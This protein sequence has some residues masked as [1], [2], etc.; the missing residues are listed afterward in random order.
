MLGLSHSVLCAHPPTFYYVDSDE[1]DF[2]LSG[3]D[4]EISGLNTDELKVEVLEFLLEVPSGWVPGIFWH[5]GQVA[6]T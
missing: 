5:A 6:S 3:G 1:E 2:G 4:R